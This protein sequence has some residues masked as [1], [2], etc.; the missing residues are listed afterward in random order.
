MFDWLDIH[1]L[2]DGG[3]PGSVVLHVSHNPGLVALS[4][5]I[6]VFASFT[7]ILAERRSEASA[8]GFPRAAWMLLCAVALGCGI[9]SMHF[10]GMLAYEVP[11]LVLYDWVPTL[12]SM[13]IAVA[14]SFVAIAW[15]NRG[16]QPLLEIPV[17]GSLMGLGIVF[18]HYVGMS[19]MRSGVAVVYEGSFF[20]RSVAFAIVAATAAL[21]MVRYAHSEQKLREFVIQVFAALLMGGAMV[22]MHFTAMAGTVLY[23]QVG[24][25]QLPAT[26]G[27]NVALAV[28]ISAVIIAIMLSAIVVGRLGRRLSEEEALLQQT[29]FHYDQI[30]ENVPDGI[31]IVDG[32]GTIQKCNRAARRLFELGENVSEM[33]IITDLVPRFSTFLA[34]QAE[35]PSPQFL[36]MEARSS[37]GREFP[38]EISVSEVEEED[39]DCLVLVTRDVSA[40]KRVENHIRKLLEENKRL[41]ATDMLTGLPNRRYLLEAINKELSRCKRYGHD[42]SILVIDIDFFK[43]INDTFG[44]SSGDDALK[45][46][47]RV[48]REIARGSDL[49]CRFGGEEFLVALP[50]TS[51]VQAGRVAERLRE[52]L[53]ATLVKVVREEELRMTCSIGVAQWFP[54][55]LFDDTLAAGDRA[56]YQAKRNG[57]NQV[58]VADREYRVADPA[59]RRRKPE[60]KA[61]DLESEGKVIPFGKQPTPKSPPG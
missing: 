21:A 33:P 38:V 54:G 59:D 22:G 1:F 58:V 31:V 30:I 2:G 46:M 7:A 39:S 45:V 10:I 26:V 28:A 15:V 8:P 42:L 16:R 52:R 37:L 17:A 11:V 53:E 23:S 14:A 25:S 50:E 57:R 61:A 27:V 5:I 24:I 36:E 55:D 20:L 32:A 40:R 44:H 6:A 35:L 18:M 3:L 29:V 41:A 51:A 4:F 60:E 12:V 56:L 19:A 47:A 43:Q 34:G 9:W 48:I 49:F 13:A